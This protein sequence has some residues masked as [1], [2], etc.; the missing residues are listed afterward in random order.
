MELS[1]NTVSNELNSYNPDLFEKLTEVINNYLVDTFGHQC[2]LK[3]G[4]NPPQFKVNEVKTNITGKYCEF[5]EFSV[6]DLKTEN[7][8]LIVKAYISGRYYPSRSCPDKK[9]PLYDLINGYMIEMKSYGENIFIF[10]IFKYLP[11]I[12]YFKQLLNFKKD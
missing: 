10:T 4:S 6:I 1:K 5:L 11:Q 2:V 7:N 9:V 8:K 3:L 12:D